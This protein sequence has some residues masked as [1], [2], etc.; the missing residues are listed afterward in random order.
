MRTNLADQVIDNRFELAEPVDGLG[1]GTCWKARDR[2]FRLHSKLVRL[3]RPLPPG[4]AGMPDTLDRTFRALQSVRHPA[5]LPVIH[6]GL[7]QGRPYV[8]HEWFDGVSFDGLFALDPTLRGDV[9]VEAARAIIEQVCGALDAALQSGLRVVHGALETRDVLVKN[10]HDRQ[11][12]VRVVFG[13]AA[14]EAGVVSD[15]TPLDD[16]RAVGR[17]LRVL[18]SP[19]AGRWRRGTPSGVVEWIERCARP[20]VAAQVPTLKALR[21]GLAGAWSSEPA[22]EGAPP[23]VPSPS[24]QAQAAPAVTPPSPEARPRDAV[25]EATTP[26]RDRDEDPFEATVRGPTTPR[27]ANAPR[28]VALEATPL[29]F[30]DATALQSAIGFEPSIEEPTDV[31]QAAPGGVVRRAPLVLP[32]I[33]DSQ[34][35][36]RRPSLRDLGP[37]R[38]PASEAALTDTVQVDDFAPGA[39]PWPQGGVAQAWAAP[40]AFVP[41]SPSPALA[42]PTAPQQPLAPP[43]SSR[44]PAIVAAL[45]IVG[46][47]LAVVAWWLLKRSLALR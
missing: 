28:P 4:T 21:D 7:W 42:P 44:W 12:E 19:A 14:W 23:S 40:P 17:L 2:R 34:E 24:P 47:L 41:P 25:E 30:F 32:S 22:R 20:D 11:P 29:T 45:A 38:A 46:T 6:H 3:L 43:R 9:P 1:P 27:Q 10:I 39:N 16:I 26:A 37:P 13:V 18:L 15:A 35:T 31:T 5:V 33:E 8:V 36:T